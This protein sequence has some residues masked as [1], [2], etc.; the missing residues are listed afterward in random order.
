[1]NLSDVLLTEDDHIAVMEKYFSEKG[2]AYHQ[3]DSYRHFTDKM[4]QEIIDETPSLYIHTKTN[5]Y[6]ATFGQVYIERACFVDESRTRY[7]YPQEARL[8]D[9]TYESPVFVDITEEFWELNEKGDF[10][11]VNTIEHRKIL[12]MKIPVMIRSSLCNLYQLSMDECVQKG[13][14]FNDPGGYFIINGKERV[15]VC[16]ERLNY[17]QVYVFEGNDE[18]SPYVAEIRSM[19]RETGHSV[20][21]QARMNKEGKNICFSLPYM[22]KEIAA[23]AVFKALNM[24][25]QDIIRFIQPSTK[26]ERVL[27]ERLIRESI[28]YTNKGK[29]IKY[30]SKASLHKVEDDEERCII[31]TEQ[32]IENELFPH[33][34]ISTPTEKCILL[35]DMLNKLFRVFLKLRPEDDRDNVSLKRIEGPGVLIGDLFRMSMKRYCDNIKKYLEKRQDIITAM[36]RTNSIT[37]VL[38]HTFSTGNWAAQKNT[39]VRTGVSQV[40]NHLTYPSTIS[41]L[42]RVVIPVGKEGKNVKIRQIHPSQTFFIDIIESP[43]GKSI[44]IVKNLALLC[45]I[46]TGVNSILIRELIEKCQHIIDCEKYMDR[47]DWWRV[48]L[49]GT[50]IGLSYQ[51]KSLYDEFQELRDMNVFSNQVSFFMDEDDH[52]IRVF[53][54]AGRYIRPVLTV[55]PGN[56]LTLTKQ[57]IKTM[58]W[59]DLLDHDIVRYVDSNEVENSLIAMNVDD[60]TKYSNHD[61]HYCEIHPSAMLGV[62]SAVIPYPE[63]NQSPRLVYQSSMVKQALGVYS[64]A[65]QHRFETVTHVMHYPQ[66]PMVSTKFDKMLKYDEMLTGCNPIVAIATYGGWNQEDS[67]M[68]NRSAVD[69]GMFVHTCYKTLVTEEHKKT[70]NSFERIEVPPPSAQ[71]KTM[72]YSKLGPNGIVLKGVPVYKGDIIIGKTLTKVQKDEDEKTDCSLAV[73]NGEEGTV[74]EIWEGL[75]EDGYKMVKIRIRQLRIPEVGDKFA[76]RS[77]QKGVCGLL[78]TQEDMPFTESGMT[79]DIIINPHCFTADN[80][81]SLYNG[82]SRKIGDLKKDEIVWSYDYANRGLTRRTNVGMEWKGFRKVV[83]I[84]L[85]D[86]RTI[87]CTPDHKFYTTEQ[88]WVEAKD[89]QLNK[90]KI[91]MGIE[92]VEDINYGDETD[93][94]L[95]TTNFTFSCDTNENREK[96]MAF[97]RILGHILT[98]GCVH[99]RYDNSEFICPVHFGHIIDADICVQDIYKITGKT[100]KI[101]TSGE[102]G[103]ASTYVVH[104]PH[105]LSQSFGMLDGITI[106]RKTRQESDW[107]TFLYTCPKSVLREFLASAFGGDGHAPYLN[108]DRPAT[109]K[110][111][112]SIHSSFKASFETKM[113]NLCMMLNKF[114]VEAEIERIRDYQNES[115]ELFHSIYINIKNN[116]KFAEN[117]GFRYC[118]EKMG[119]LSLYKSYLEFQERVKK[120]SEQVLS[121]VDTYT[122]NMSIAK[123]LEKARDEM[124]KGPVLNEYYSLSNI[125]QVKNRRKENRSTD[126]LHLSYKYFPTFTEYL[127]DMGCLEW[128]SKTDYITTREKTVIPAFHMRPIH[129]KDDGEENVC[130]IGVEEFH[131]FICNGHTVMNCMPSRMTL[132]QLTEMLLGKTGSLTGVLGDATAFTKSSINPVETIAAQLSNFGFER[133]GNERLMSGYTGEMMQAEIFIGTAYYQR[134]KH[135]VKDKMHCLTL[136]HEVLTMEGWKPISEITVEDRV[137]TLGKNDVLVYQQPTHVWRY[138]QYEGELYHIRS[139]SI[140]LTVT[141]NH[142]MWVTDSENNLNQFRFVEAKDCYGKQYVYKK[143]A[144]WQQTGYLH[145]GTDSFDETHDFMRLFWYHPFTK[146]EEEWCWR[147]A[148]SQ[149]R[150]LINAITHGKTTLIDTQEN[151]DRLQRLCLHAEW[152]AD[153]EDAEEDDIKDNNNKNKKITITKGICHYPKVK[154]TEERITTHTKE[155]GIDVMCITVPNEIFYVRRNGKAVWT[156]NSRARGNVT[157][158][159]HQPSEG[160]S[161]D[162]GLRTGEMERDALIAHGGSAFIQETFFD[163]SDVYQVNVCDHCGG[164]VSAA[165]E[166]RTC[167]SADIAKTN[168]PYCAKLLLQELQALG[169]SIKINTV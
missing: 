158:M 141:S 121:L 135:L 21:V 117:I 132:S 96:A 105:E 60:L 153:I 144:L 22:S 58:S 16:Q 124:K 91:V 53:C 156:G 15:L 45:N 129:I 106:G 101:C 102:K 75:N 47:T 68:L 123:A 134:L 6:K 10:E 29:A 62:C 169:V 30:I 165:K 34:G 65:F 14:C 109:I 157:M 94:K 95:Q 54:D 37:A 49:N 74:D 163:M 143:D 55:Q 1:M 42:R 73:G 72:N 120:Q 43:E 113:Q 31:Y 85:Q 112:K 26:E 140:D 70:N 59:S 136:D 167:K 76:S 33:M 161:K 97:A 111:S 107:P 28:Q 155:D 78:L 40:I 23:G 11:K 5:K 87:R 142:R 36:N 4:L 133:Y 152:S 46:T 25:S 139:S 127:E 63:H 90:D 93:W 137:A 64:L 84:T 148:A 77:S 125:N 115:K 82:L 98:D 162:G 166:C 56:M 51:P 19:S 108:K 168:I 32:V 122:T 8:R 2:P 114:D 146:K 66:K 151:V 130:C 159:H 7:I 39:Y 61:Y 41:H 50:L 116:L 17:N 80:Q 164:M 79:P 18:K 44:G 24:D 160:R 3:F 71:N 128:Y 110:F 99:Q 147:I 138:P 12:L 48:Y 89:L 92:G 67:V 69:R 126:V 35:G 13:E 100:P 149:S 38:K 52:E 131:N 88:K 9:L 145:H 154:K 104:I 119:R 86:G 118:T 27:V 83:K 103:K 81:V 150:L 57:H 20:L